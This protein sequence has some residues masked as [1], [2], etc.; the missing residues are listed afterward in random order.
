MKIIR[1][2]WTFKR[3]HGDWWRVQVVM[4]VSSCQQLI[5]SPELK[6]ES[7]LSHL[8]ERLGGRECRPGTRRSRGH[9]ASPKTGNQN[10]PCLSMRSFVGIFF[11]FFFFFPTFLFWWGSRL[12]ILQ[13]AASFYTTCVSRLLISCFSSIRH[14]N[15]KRTSHGNIA[16]FC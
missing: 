5:Q 7:L 4:F 10:S 1:T 3:E 14:W 9:V 11:I 6:P 8:T 15:E 13:C 12:S 2:Q 16:I